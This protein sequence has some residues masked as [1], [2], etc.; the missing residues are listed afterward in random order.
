VLHARAVTE[1]ESRIYEDSA[2]LRALAMP[3]PANPWR[4]K[5]IVETGDFYAVGDVDLLGEFDPTRA[6]V[7]QKPAADPAIQAAERLPAFQEFLRFSQVPL[8]RVSPAPDLENGKT[9]EVIDLRF[10]SPQ[11]PAFVVSATLDSNLRPVSSSFQFG[12]SRQR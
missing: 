9:V 7:Y 3:G 8:W 1:L 11:A 4:W 12:L 2:P 5:G 6:T 10:G